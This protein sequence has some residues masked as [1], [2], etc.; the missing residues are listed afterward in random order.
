MPN[1]VS[2]SFPDNDTALLNDVYKP[3]KGGS[4]T[5]GSNASD[6]KDVSAFVGALSRR[7]IC[8]SVTFNIQSGQYSDQIDLSEIRGASEKNTITIQSRARHRDSVLI[9]HKIIGANDNFI[10]RFNGTDHV[11][12]RDISLKVTGNQ[13]YSTLLRMNNS[14]S[15]NNIINCSF[16]GQKN[17]LGSQPIGAL[18]HIGESIDS[19]NVFQGNTFHNG[20]YGL[21]MKGVSSI[22][23][24]LVLDSNSF[25]GQ[26]FMAVFL[27]DQYSPKIRNNTITATGL[28]LNG[29]NMTNCLDDIQIVNNKI[30]GNVVNC[31]DLYFCES[32]RAKRG[33]IANNYLQAGATL[34]NSTLH[35][36]GVK[37]NY[38]DRLNLVHNTIAITG[39]DTLSSAFHCSRS[40]NL[41]IYNN[42]F[43]NLAG[44]YALYYGY[45]DH[46]ANNVDYNNNYTNGGYLAYYNS[47]IK[48]LQGWRISSNKDARSLSLNPLF[49]SDSSYRMCEKRLYNAGF[50]NQ[51]V[52]QDI[53]GK[54]RKTPNPSIGA[55]EQHFVKLDLGEDTSVCDSI[56]IR[57]NLSHDKHFW[58]TGDTSAFIKVDSSGTYKLEVKNSCFSQTDS[59]QIRV[60]TE[61]ELSLGNDTTLCKFDSIN[62]R[63]GFNSYLWNTGDTINQIEVKDSGEYWLVV[64]N[65]CGTGSDTVSVKM[66]SI[67]EVNLGN[68]TTICDSLRIT[69]PVK[70][71]YLW[72]D[73]SSKNSYLVRNSGLVWLRLQNQCGSFRDSIDIQ[74]ESKPKIDLGDDT[75]VCEQYRLEINDTNYNVLWNTGDTTSHILIDTTGIYTAEVTSKRKCKFRLDSILV[76][77]APPPKPDLGPDTSVKIGSMVHLTTNKPYRTYLWSTGS[78]RDTLVFERNEDSVMVISVQVAD[79]NGCTGFDTIQVFILEVVGFPNKAN[80]SRIAVYPN[81]VGSVL[82]VSHQHEGH[83]F[84]LSV[85]N[86]LGQEV[87]SE[88]IESVDTSIN[89]GHLLPGQYTLKLN[90]VNGEIS[91]QVKLVVVR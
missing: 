50:K 45:S 42:S 3:L 9:E 35:K 71:N 82:H 39:S 69:I 83:F 20:A 18:V 57:S 81:P 63:N 85:V 80:V 41:D 10:F 29:I 6:F 23:Q 66:D 86:N 12:I 51:A 46:R 8:G 19:A 26:R 54:I 65:N 27:H 62:V 55:L 87:I 75:T 78:D 79:S 64:A 25:L 58:N 77:I 68:D 13:F 60:E 88:K 33:L 67:P 14:A 37:L 40:Y 61:P 38:C 59:I 74:I 76:T 31:L 22:G 84:D 30:G 49:I 1:G 24:G 91:Y 53:E 47:N 56:V 28:M 52:P 89:M 5:V 32:R 4:Y 36:I 16:T 72:G 21:Y 90:E 11:T 17:M 48:S 34:V 44:G 43:N 2:D 15:N 7:G 70:A 73:S